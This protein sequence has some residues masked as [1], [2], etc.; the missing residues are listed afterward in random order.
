[1]NLLLLI[2]IPLLTAI[3]VLLARND[4]QVRWFSLVGSAIQLILALVLL[5]AIWKEKSSGNPSDILFEQTYP[6]F[7]SLNIHFHIGVDGIA[8]SMILLTALVVLA[9]VLVSWTV[10]KMVKEFY[11]LLILLGWGAYGFFISLDLFVLFFFLEIAVIPKYM[12]I[13]IWGSGKKEYSANKLALMLMGGSA[14]VFVGLLGL[15]FPCP[16]NRGHSTCWKWQSKTF[17]WVTNW[18]IFPCFLLALAF[19]LHC[20]PFIPG[21]RMD[22]RQRQLQGL[23]PCRN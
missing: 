3:L 23:C 13:G 14:L 2:G 20:F 1:M 17:Q 4:R 16:L 19:S 10:D 21:C 8:A 6:L 18:S 11:L 9:G 12:L 7:P 22:T 15:Y 5:V